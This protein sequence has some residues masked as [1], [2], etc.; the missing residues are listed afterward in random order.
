MMSQGRPKES[1]EYYE[2]SLAI[3]EALAEETGTVESRRDLSVSYNKLGDIM[4][5]QGRPK[6]AAEYYG[7]DLAI[8]E[9]LAEETGTVEAYDDLAVSY[10]KM[11]FA[12]QANQRAYRQKALN[13][14]TQLADL[15]P[16]DP[17]F[18]QR[19]DLVKKALG[20]K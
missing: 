1:A 3:C 12:D 11:A 20:I 7:K 10:Y 13:I 6:E 17:T 19:R 4:K 16:D 5:A 9:A 14:W 15:C 2:K 8:A 18:A